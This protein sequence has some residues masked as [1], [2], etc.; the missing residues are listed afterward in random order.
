[1]NIKGGRDENY[2][3]NLKDSDVGTELLNVW[4]SSS[5]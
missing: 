1:M 4:T 5:D 3:Q 2:W